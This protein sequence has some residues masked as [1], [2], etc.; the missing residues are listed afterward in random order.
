MHGSCFYDVTLRLWPLDYLIEWELDAS[1]LGTSTRLGR[2]TSHVPLQELLGRIHWFSGEI[3]TQ[4]RF[5]ASMSG[6]MVATYPNTAVR[7]RVET[8]PAEGRICYITSTKELQIFRRGR[9]GLYAR[10]P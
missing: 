2:P 6:Q 4:S 3:V 1:K 7:D 10:I 8:N 9:W 5:Q